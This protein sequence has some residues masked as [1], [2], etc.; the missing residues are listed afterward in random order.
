MS[1]NILD[2]NVNQASLEGE[3]SGKNVHIL[4]GNVL[5]RLT[6]YNLDNLT[7]VVLY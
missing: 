6:L 3:R 2:K 1:Y 4:K 5:A 7:E